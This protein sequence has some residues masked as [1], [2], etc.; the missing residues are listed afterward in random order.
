MKNGNTNGMGV[1]AHP[2]AGKESG[3]HMP[4]M[5]AFA[6]KLGT[7][8]PKAIKPAVPATPKLAIPKPKQ[9]AKLRT[10][11]PGTTPPKQKALGPKISMPKPVVAPEVAKPRTPKGFER[12]RRIPT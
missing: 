9:I 4:K 12:S 7:F 11:L 10:A 1:K 6:P 2:T 5:G 8:K 3:M